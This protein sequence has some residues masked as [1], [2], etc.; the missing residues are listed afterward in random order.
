MRLSFIVAFCMVSATEALAQTNSL[1]SFVDSLN[2]AWQQTNTTQ[3]LSLLNQRLSSN[4]NDICALCI[5]AS[6][7]VLVDGVLTNARDA[8]DQ[9]N[10][11]VQ[12]GSNANAKA[13]SQEMRDEI[14]SIPLSE[15]GTRTAGQINQIHDGLPNCFP[16][17]QKCQWLATKTAGSS[18]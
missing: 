9:F 11:A 7:H 15:S 6:Y 14:Y 1:Q 13:V 8:A 16:M 3:V 4:S 12:Q 5:K 10:S 17:I 2:S 18:P